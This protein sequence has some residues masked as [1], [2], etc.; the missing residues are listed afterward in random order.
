MPSLKARAGHDIE[1]STG[2]INLDLG[3]LS[4]T[5]PETGQLPHTDC[6]LRMREG[7]FPK[8][9]RAFDLRSPVTES[10]RRPSPHHKYVQG[11]RMLEL[12]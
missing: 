7:P 2:D 1:D 8:R 4:Q 11:Q 10:N 12:H 3:G 5:W 6:P 9:E